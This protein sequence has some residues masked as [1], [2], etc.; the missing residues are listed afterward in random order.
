MNY[1]LMTSN[2]FY[3]TSFFQ[4]NNSMNTTHSEKTH[5]FGSLAKVARVYENSMVFFKN[6]AGIWY[7]QQ[8]QLV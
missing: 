6:E 8:K 2:C 1:Y 4:R 5:V 7:K 3:K